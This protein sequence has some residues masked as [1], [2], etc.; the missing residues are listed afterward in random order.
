MKTR[1][2]GYIAPHCYEITKP[3][4]FGVYGRVLVIADIHEGTVKDTFHLTQT[5]LR[6][7]QAE[8]IDGGITTNM[9]NRYGLGT[10]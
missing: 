9:R 5:L 4:G 3:Y 2:K 10:D 1:D 7:Q 8:E 6:I